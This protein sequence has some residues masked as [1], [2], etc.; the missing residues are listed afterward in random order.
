MILVTGGA[1]YIGCV[2]VRELLERGET[3]R[4]FDKLFFGEEPLSEFRDRIELVEGDVRSIDAEAFAVVIKFS[5]SRVK[6]SNPIRSTGKDFNAIH[7]WVIA[8]FVGC[9][10]LTVEKA[11]N[12]R[13]K[14]GLESCSLH[15]DANDVSALRLKLKVV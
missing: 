13:I 15:D 3:V 7:S 1:G 9:S 8:T 11:E 6:D 5:F 14:R 2:L 10:A 4:V 12:H